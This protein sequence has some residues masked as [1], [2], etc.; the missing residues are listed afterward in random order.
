VIDAVLLDVGGVFV[1][2]DHQ[3]IR[4]LVTAHGGTP[5]QD[6]LDNAHY[7]GIAAGEEA[8]ARGEAFDWAAYRRTVLRRAGVPEADLEAASADFDA[9]LRDPAAGVWKQQLTGAAEG[10]ARI[11]EL[12][13]PL[14]IVSN[15]DG[16]IEQLLTQLELCYLRAADRSA[17][18]GAPME[19]IIDSTVVGVEKPDPAIFA[20]ALKATGTDPARTVHVGDTLYADVVGAFAAGLR[21]LHLDPIGWCQD[22]RH[23]HVADLAGVA[24]LVA[25]ERG[26]I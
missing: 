10:L 7:E 23:E 21:P 4:Q 26:A 25:A 2:P 5:T 18:V 12:G 9:A 20:M 16:T 13:V 11:A 1:M 24:D 22:D 3:M 14:A 19:I 17:G 8:V 15:A 6:S